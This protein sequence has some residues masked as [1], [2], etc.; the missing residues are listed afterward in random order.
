LRVEELRVEAD[1]PTPSL[2]RDGK[3]EKLKSGK[4]K[5]KLSKIEDGRWDSLKK[6]ERL[7]S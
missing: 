2:R 6:A 1:P 3:A 5:A 7:K 4:L